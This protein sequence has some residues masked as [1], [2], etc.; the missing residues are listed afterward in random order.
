MNLTPVGG[1]WQADPLQ[2]G[3][4]VR[5]ARR[6]LSCLLLASA[7]PGLAQ[8]LAQPIPEIVVLGE[9]AAALRPQRSIGG[10]DLLAYGAGTVRDLIDEVAADDGER[11]G[12]IILL[13]NGRRV[14]GLGDIETYPAEAI[15][16]L[17]LLPRESGARVGAPAGRR[18][19]N[20]V[21]KPQASIA[22]AR[23]QAR[24]ATEGGAEGL[25]L[26]L[27]A[28]RIER[29]QRLNVAVQLRRDGA[30]FE[31]ER[32]IEQAAGAPATL[33]RARTLRPATRG[34]EV[35]L[36]AADR[37]LPGVD[38]LVTLRLS[39]LRNRSSLGLSDLGS[40]I[41]RLSHSR[42]LDLTTQINAER[43]SWSFTLDGGSRST[44]RSTAT[45]SGAGAPLVRSVTR[46]QFVDLLA[47]GP[48][49][50]LPAGSVHLTLGASLRRDRLDRD[51][52]DQLSNDLARISREVRAGIDVPIL[53]RGGPLPRLG[54][55]TMRA[56]FSR[57]T[58]DGDTLRGRTLSARWSPVEPLQLTASLARSRTAPGIDLIGEPLIETAGVRYFDPLRSETIE[59]VTLTGGRRDLPPQSFVSR[60]LTVD[61]RPV[62]TL[63]LLLT[64]EY[65]AV[66]NS[67]VVSVLPPG[68]DLVTRLF[69][70]RFERDAA[71]R[72]TRIDL[73]PILFP[74]QRERQLRTAISLG[75]PLGKGGRRPRLQVAG[76]YRLL[77]A[78]RLDPGGGF[79]IV[80]LLDRE[81]IALGGAM[82]P[83]Q[84]FD[85]TLGYAERGL[86]VRLTGE[87]Q[88]R[89][90]LAAGPS[91]EVLT[92]GALTVLNLRTFVD[93]RRL[94]AGST[95]LRNARFGLSVNNLFNR[96]EQVRGGRGITPLAYQPALRDPIG[97]SVEFEFRRTF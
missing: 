31:S 63:D 23:G 71:G 86:G 18:V 30:L 36:S 84:Q 93:G 20:I 25:T 4:S 48:L 35:T 78:S 7:A 15:E 77:L 60:R 54:E 64:G 28:T 2:R 67:N 53:S 94:A 33:A 12:G 66:R 56:E 5:A 68:S 26:D 13:V 55:L 61:L 89:S 34:G 11:A 21:L 32:E 95:M 96:R 1:L 80:D 82:R 6:I 10:E 24:V 19:Y 40:T 85:F 46:S 29:P 91:E 38:G 49:A 75:V 47:H 51:A 65:V 73:R 70:D 79:G 58:T 52:P 41:E 17:D 57:G 27:G 16:R 42:S 39:Q 43:G 90:F 59:V 37:L 9:R 74:G 83:R 88:T 69:P 50:R 76:S 8:S 97:R 62:K 72:L 14:P 87:R 22:T 92:F 81:A 3:G 44:R 45:D